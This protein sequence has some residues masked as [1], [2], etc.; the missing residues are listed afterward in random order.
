M[1]LRSKIDEQ[2]A[3]SVMLVKLKLAF[4]DRFRYDEEGVPRIWRPGD[5]IDSAFRKAKDEVRFF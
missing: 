1:S 4:E 2:T 3:D 5:D